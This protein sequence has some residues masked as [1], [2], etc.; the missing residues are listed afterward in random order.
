MNKVL[1]SNK[2]MGWQVNKL[3]VYLP[4]YALKNSSQK[5]F[6]CYSVFYFPCLQATC[7]PVHPFT[8]SFLIIKN[9]LT[10]K[11]MLYAGEG[12]SLR[13]NNTL[14]SITYEVLMFRL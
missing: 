7:S 8:L 12:L 2:F 13:L 4:T 9:I 6:I 1:L 5:T 14:T 3:F 10:C 11:S